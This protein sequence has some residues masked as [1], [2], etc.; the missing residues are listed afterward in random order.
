MNEYRL[1]LSKKKKIISLLPYVF[2]HSLQ[3]V[4]RELTHIRRE[5][6]KTYGR[7]AILILQQQL[8]Q[9][10][11]P[12]SEIDYMDQIKLRHNIIL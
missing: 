3:I 2:A 12:L 6:A 8:E 10:L 4:E 11:N 5:W 7:R 9:C 1:F